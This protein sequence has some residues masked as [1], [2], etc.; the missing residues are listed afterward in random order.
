MYGSVVDC[1]DLA[2]FKVLCGLNQDSGC[3]APGSEPGCTG[4]RI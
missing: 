1:V 3:D 4:G 2:N